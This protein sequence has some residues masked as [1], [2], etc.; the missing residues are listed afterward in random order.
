[1]EKHHQ[2]IKLSI[3]AENDRGRLASVIL[4][5]HG[6][7]CISVRRW[8]D[9]FTTPTEKG[10]LMQL[11]EWK[12]LLKVSKLIQDAACTATLLNWKRSR[13][14]IASASTKKTKNRE[15]LEA[16]WQLSSK[17][18]VKVSSIYGG[19][20]D[21]R[22]T[23]FDW[24]TKTRMYSHRGV[25]L[26]INEWY[27]LIENASKLTLELTRR[28][29][30]Q[31]KSEKSGANIQKKKGKINRKSPEIIRKKKR[32]IVRKLTPEKS[33]KANKPV[34]CARKQRKALA[35][36]MQTRYRSRQT[37]LNDGA[38]E[39]KECEACTYINAVTALLKSNA[40]S[41]EKFQL[42]DIQ[43]RARVA[44]PTFRR[45]SAARAARYRKTIEA[46]N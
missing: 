42:L 6:E 26:R 9:Q 30:E 10:V 37:R 25:T 24:K 33:S 40:F 12:K 46:L 7:W 35:T 1:M 3:D 23:Y 41:K 22:H 36:A 45:W 38:K 39:D 8:D 15:Q 17:V 2:R 34:K 11:D 20:V 14:Q 44:K 4:S 21:L 19:N 29:L 43:R 28:M 13:V 18:A 31:E 16:S 5:K 27:T 32:K